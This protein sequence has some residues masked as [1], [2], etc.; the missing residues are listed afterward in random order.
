MGF[1]FGDYSGILGQWGSGLIKLLTTLL[2][3]V[4]LLS[5]CMSS[6]IKLMVKNTTKYVIQVCTT[7]QV[8][9]TVDANVNNNVTLRYYDF[10]GFE[11]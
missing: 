3:I 5:A 7:S 1:I 2:L 10:H 11:E 8:C 4:L 6:L 9:T